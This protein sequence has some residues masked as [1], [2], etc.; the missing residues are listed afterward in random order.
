[1]QGIRG[2]I[3]YEGQNVDELEQDFRAGIDEYLEVC[4]EKGIEHKNLLQVHLMY[5]YL[6]THMYKQFKG[7]GIGD[8]SKR[9][10]K[11]CNRRK[12]ANYVCNNE[13]KKSNR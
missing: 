7:A 5:E 4:K 10:C 6:L 12:T 8:K 11:I 3:S 9:L 1:V 13:K 2:L